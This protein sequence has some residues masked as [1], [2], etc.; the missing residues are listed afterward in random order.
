[1]LYVLYGSDRE[2]IRDESHKILAGL[3]KKRPGAQVFRLSE[4]GETLSRLPELIES[5]GLF[6]QK[7]VVV[8]DFVLEFELVRELLLAHAEDIAASGHI[9]IVLAE[10][11]DAA[12]KRALEKHAHEMRTFEKKD[13]AE[14]PFNIFFLADAIARRD[15]KGAWVALQR[16]LLDGFAPEEIHGTVWWQIKTQLRVSRGDTD[17]MKPFAVTKARGALA[18]FSEKELSDFIRKLLAMYHDARAGGPSLDIALE[19][20]VLGL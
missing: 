15:K 8:L 12:T 20:F 14:K 11:L 18:H 3:L 16:A 2:K 10:K 17:G 9:F 4:E 1:M 5:Q 7:H 19:Q 6:E 13:T